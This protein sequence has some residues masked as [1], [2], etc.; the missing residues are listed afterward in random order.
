MSFS[1]SPPIGFTE[2]FSDTSPVIA[3]CGVTAVPVTSEERAVV[4]VIPAERP[5]LGV[6]RS[7]T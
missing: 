4:R 6:E 7:G 5:S 1:G 3:T 2:P